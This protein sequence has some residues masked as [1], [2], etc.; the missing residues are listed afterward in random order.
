MPPDMAI[1]A[2][3]APEQELSILSTLVDLGYVREGSPQQGSARGH[4]IFQVTGSEPCIMVC[5]SL[6][7]LPEEERNTG[8]VMLMFFPDGDR[9]LHC[10][11]TG[12]IDYIPQGT[13]VEAAVLQTE[14]FASSLA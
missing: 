10:D 9:I 13:S 3:F 6:G 8:Y 1:K 14:S 4:W 7:H 2:A 11:F 12:R 5:P